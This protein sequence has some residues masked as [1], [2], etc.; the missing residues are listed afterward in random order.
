M[1]FSSI[2][3]SGSKTEAKKTLTT[4]P[5]HLPAIKLVLWIS[6]TLVLHSYS[7]NLI[8]FAFGW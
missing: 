2:L 1:I 8:I 5:Q 4:L 3:I 6:L 7:V